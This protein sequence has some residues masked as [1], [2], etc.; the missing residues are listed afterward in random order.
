[1]RHACAVGVLGAL[2]LTACVEERASREQCQMIFDR[3]VTLELAE[4][5]YADP[6]LTARRQAELASRYRKQLAA[7]VGKPIPPDAQA[8]V[9]RAE[10][11]EEVSHE[12][13]R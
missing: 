4:M 3:L 11:T 8:C 5:G 12:C 13:L 7:C 9:A 1:M 6:A 2:M 10:T